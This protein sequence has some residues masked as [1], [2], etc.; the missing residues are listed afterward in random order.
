MALIMSASGRAM[1]LQCQ[2]HHQLAAAQVWPS[3]RRRV[4]R[5]SEVIGLG[6]EVPWASRRHLLQCSTV[7]WRCYTSPAWSSGHR[8]KRNDGRALA[9][10]PS[11]ASAD[12][13]TRKGATGEHV[14]QP[15]P[16]TAHSTARMRAA[17]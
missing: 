7:K 4:Q 8:A 6:H 1:A 10:L 11:A 12:P 13:S 16:P 17:V 2:L 5:S 15:H 3:L 9:V 14:G